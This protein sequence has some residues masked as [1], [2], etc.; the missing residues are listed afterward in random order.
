MSTTTTALP[1]PPRATMP[2][3]ERIRCLQQFHTGAERIRDLY[4]PVCLVAFPTAFFPRVVFV[5]SPQGAHD[6]LSGFDGSLDKTGIVH[7]ESRRMVN[8]SFSFAHDEWLPR[9]RT[10][11]PVFSQRHVESFAGHMAGAAGDVARGLAGADV[12]DANREMRRL[13]LAVL[14]RSLFG[15]DLGQEADRLE[16]SVPTALSYVTGRITNPVRAPFGL[17]TP[18]RHRF[19]HHLRVWHGVIDAAV[20]SY[21][22]DPSTA[23]AELLQ[24]LHEARD[25]DT[26]RALTSDEI[27]EE[28]KTFLI[29]GHDTTSTTL[30]YALW[31]L[32]SDFELQAAV[33]EEAAALPDPLGPEHVPQ[34]GLTVRVLH[35]ALRLCPPAPAVSRHVER[36][37]VID[38]FVVEPGCELF[39]S[40]Y[41]LHHDPT[42]WEDPLR[43]DPDRFLPDAVRGRNRWSYLPFG[44]GPRSCIGSHF[45]MLEATLG[46]AT[47]VRSLVVESVDPT[48]EVALPFTMTAAGPVPLR[49][50]ARP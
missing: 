21:L 41:A 4:G 40:I 43:F 30:A 15:R 29:A 36:E 6:A 32:G 17:P 34:L 44:G 24:R 1:A 39:I 10:L 22:A 48:F 11:A 19:R 31:Q 50:H 35:E 13:T 9:R 3:R 8:G 45:A 33:A 38:G 46:L 23:D 18:A 28:L 2:L 12:V 7:R 14:G 16:V 5:T 37:T 27:R 47:L 26:G 20:E 42:L 25:P 49:V